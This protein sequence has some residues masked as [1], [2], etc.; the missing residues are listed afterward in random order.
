MKKALI[1][2]AV[3]IV[4]I[5]AG[6]FYIISRLDSLIA[7]AI[8][9]SGSKA[10]QTT[11]TVSGVDISLRDGRG[12][13]DG[14]V[15]ANPEGFQSPN[16]FSLENITL[17]IDVQ[18]LRDDVLVINSISIAE[19]VVTAEITK[20]GATNIDVLR[21]RVEEFAGGTSGEGGE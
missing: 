2:V 17:E 14:F 11:V 19:P 21:K 1:V 5:A 6:I 9:R 20:D 7:Q 15:V 8:E 12:E 10:T 16:A 18:S 4:L 3:V 13:I